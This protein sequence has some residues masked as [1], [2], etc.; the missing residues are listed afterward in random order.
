MVMPAHQVHDQGEECER[1]RQKRVR[2]KEL[3]G[4]V[5]PC[6]LPLGV[7]VLIDLVVGDRHHDDEDPQQDDADQELVDDPHRHHRRLQILGTLS[8][9]L[10][11]L[12]QSVL[13]DLV[14]LV[15]LQEHAGGVVHRLH[16]ALAD[17]LHVDVLRGAG[18]VSEAVGAV[19]KIGDSVIVGVATERLEQNPEEVGEHSPGAGARVELEVLEV[20][21]H[22]R[23]AAGERQHDHEE[24]DEEHLQRK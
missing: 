15:H 24:G 5:E 17:A 4:K 1:R 22:E 12:C 19:G 2:V 20:V 16:P 23:D 8:S 21:E 18:Q 13:G 7:Q 11:A 3:D 10:N 14:E 9:A 6:V